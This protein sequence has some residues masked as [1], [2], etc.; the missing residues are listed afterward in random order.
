MADETDGY[1]DS[2]SNYLSRGYRVLSEELL[3]PDIALILSPDGNRSIV[4][5]DE[6]NDPPN[7]YNEQEQRAVIHI[8]NWRIGSR[9]NC[10]ACGQSYVISA[11][12]ERAS[13]D[14]IPITKEIKFVHCACGVVI[15][16]YDRYEA[17]SVPFDLVELE[18]LYH[19][20]M[21]RTADV[22]VRYTL[23]QHGHTLFEEVGV[24][25]QHTPQDTS[26][27]AIPGFRFFNW[28]GEYG[29]GPSFISGDSPP[30][31]AYDVRIFRVRT[32]Q[33]EADTFEEKVWRPNLDT[34]ETVI[35][36]VRDIPDN[37]ANQRL[38]D[39]LLGA[40]EKQ[41]LQQVQLKGRP[42]GPAF[43]PDKQIFLDKLREAYSFLQKVDGRPSQIDVAAQM[44]YSLATFKRRLRAFGIT[45]PPSANAF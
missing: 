43:D 37:Y 25:T 41:T 13:D 36:E 30:F 9:F 42:P 28:A 3:T 34:W 4:I 38:R 32:Y 8:R 15:F 44:D 14:I 23:G 10:P 5:G 6:A 16:T 21:S 22:F 24:V 45:W 29:V 39:S 11:P 26:L 18:P 27:T 35:R 12:D 19:L 33:R 20:G 31:H 17:I 1:K 7:Q 2:W 40:N